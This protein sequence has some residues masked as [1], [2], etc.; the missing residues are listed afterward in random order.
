MSDE[1]SYE[2]SNAQSG[3]LERLNDRFESFNSYWLKP[4]KEVI[5]DTGENEEAPEKVMMGD[6][7]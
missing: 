7:I 4:E 6:K 2:S 1:D 5:T 3:I